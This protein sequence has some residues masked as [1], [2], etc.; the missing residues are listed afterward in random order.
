MKY[1][2]VLSG[3]LMG[4]SSK[5]R[6][7][8]TIFMPNCCVMWSQRKYIRWGGAMSNDQAELDS[9]FDGM[10]AF[11]E[12]ADPLVFYVDRSS[13]ELPHIPTMNMAWRR[14]VACLGLIGVE[15]FVVSPSLG[16][17]GLISIDQK[18]VTKET[19]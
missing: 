18:I 2:V 1:A 16:I 6:L 10:L 19:S 11:H 13:S 15:G 14:L 4:A 8:P 7:L 5:R 12:P 17:S 9:I 3:V